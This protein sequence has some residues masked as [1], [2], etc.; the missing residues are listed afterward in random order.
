[1]GMKLNDLNAAQSLSGCDFVL[2]REQ[3]YGDTKNTYRIGK[4]TFLQRTVHLIKYY[5]SGNYRK[6][7]KEMRLDALRDLEKFAPLA[8]VRDYGAGGDGGAKDQIEERLTLLRTRGVTSRK[9][10]SQ[11]QSLGEFAETAGAHYTTGTAY[12]ISQRAGWIDKS[13]SSLSSETGCQRYIKV[14][15][16]SVAELVDIDGQ[17]KNVCGLAALDCMTSVLLA[18]GV[19]RPHVD[20]ENAETT[21]DLDSFGSDAQSIDAKEERISTATDFLK[22]LATEPHGETDEFMFKWSG[23]R[24]VGEADRGKF[25][26]TSFPG[27]VVQDYGSTAP[28]FVPRVRILTPIEEL[29]QHVLNLLDKFPYEEGKGLAIDKGKVLDMLRGAEGEGEMPAQQQ[30]WVLDKLLKFL[31]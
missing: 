29:Q 6:N 5:V 30:K 22:F 24:D 15:P 10:V 20:G 16:L 18:D 8:R 9:F 19:L 4:S 1:M 23:S 26:V 12:S 2:V 3:H 14:G 27:L 28:G 13:S 21:P 11:V 31:N 25:V 7:V 17:P